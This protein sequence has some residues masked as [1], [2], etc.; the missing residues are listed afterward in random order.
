MA[1]MHAAQTNIATRAKAL[2]S[3]VTAKHGIDGLWRY[4]D[5]SIHPVEQDALGAA[6]MDMKQTAGGVGAEAN[7]PFVP[8][9]NLPTPAEIAEK[10]A[11]AGEFTPRGDPPAMALPTE[12]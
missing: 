11:Q 1:E 10:T 3:E 6:L 7:P 12:K 2:W 9:G 5:G 4:E 8:R